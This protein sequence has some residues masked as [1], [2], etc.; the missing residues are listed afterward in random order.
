MTE[1]LPCCRY[2]AYFRSEPKEIEAEIPGLRVLGSGY[3]SVRAGD[4]LC[5]RHG[6]YLPATAAC[7]DYHPLR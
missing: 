3:A 7:R 4:G 1:R 2:C 6:R 5:R